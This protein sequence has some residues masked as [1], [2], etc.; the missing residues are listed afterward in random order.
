M[1]GVK[2]TSFI[3]SPMF[4]LSRMLARRLLPLTFPVD[5][6]HQSTSLHLQVAHISLREV[7]LMSIHQ[8]WGGGLTLPT[9]TLKRQRFRAKK[10]LFL[11]K[12]SPNFF[13][14]F[15]MTRSSYSFESYNW[16]SILS[17][18]NVTRC[19]LVHLI[20][21]IFQQIF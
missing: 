5:V 15:L 7:T 12:Y 10:Y 14:Q 20:C 4:P 21:C 1:L 6:R 8:A 16:F 13:T 9:S 18:D 19:T 2:F 17:F 11:E 3:I